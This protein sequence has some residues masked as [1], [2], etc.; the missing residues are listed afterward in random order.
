M[1]KSI[2]YIESN[3][4]ED[5]TAGMIAE[6]AGYSLF[7]FGRVFLAYYGMPVMEYVLKRRLSLALH[8][9]LNGAKVLDTALLYGFKTASG[10]SKAFR[11]H[12]HCSPKD[13][14]KG[15]I[16]NLSDSN[17]KSYSISK[18]ILLKEMRIEKRKSFLV[19]GYSSKCENAI[20]ETTKDVSAIWSE[21]PLESYLDHLYAKLNPPKHG[22][23]G[24]Y[25]QREDG[26]YYIL[27]IIVENFKKVSSDMACIV[28]PEATYA[29]FTTQQIM[30]NEY[31]DAFVA[32][33]RATWRGIFDVWIEDSAFEYDFEKFDFEYYDERCHSQV[34]PVMEIWIP[35]KKSR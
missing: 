3:I 25:Q 23:I 6:N 14:Q 24:I 35:I 33:I 34:D 29:V 20:V 28:I 12:Y 5:L 21:K 32:T 16:L 22:E 18:E 7:H 27:G 8:D 30:G 10:F 15:L 17:E 1:E 26:A 4:K 13:F 11:R 9:I 31:P 19:A 2:D